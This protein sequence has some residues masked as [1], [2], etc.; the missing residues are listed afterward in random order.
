M[1]GAKNHNPPPPQ[2]L[3]RGSA[4][5]ESNKTQCGKK[6]T[7]WQDITYNIFTQFLSRNFLFWNPQGPSGV[8]PPPLASTAYFLI[9]LIIDTSS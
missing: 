1:H 6:P 7:K 8:P 3:Y 5:M 2:N 9:L 4:N